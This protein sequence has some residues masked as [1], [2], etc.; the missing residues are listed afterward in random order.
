M[1]ERL[2]IVSLHTEPALRC[3]AAQVPLGM[4]VVQIYLRVP[5]VDLWS[6][7]TAGCGL[8]LLIRFGLVEER[9][10]E[11]GKKKKGKEIH[12]LVTML[13]DFV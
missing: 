5:K 9:K 3:V 4:N 7:H 12:V 2:A 11:V 8:Y 1:H 6:T 10:K 13:E